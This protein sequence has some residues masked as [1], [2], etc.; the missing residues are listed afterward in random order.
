MIIIHRNCV[1]SPKC[2]LKSLCCGLAS[3][4]CKFVVVVWVS[5]ILPKMHTSIQDG[6]APVIS[7]VT[8]PFVGVSYPSW[9]MDMLSNF[10][11]Y[12]SFDLKILKVLF[13]NLH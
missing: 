8:T 13:Q 7:R 6:P 12:N 4:L 10:I 9:Y 11:F 3:I 2:N 1:V 5:A